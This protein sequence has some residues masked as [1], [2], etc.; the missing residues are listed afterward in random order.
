MTIT[1][2]GTSGITGDGSGLTNLTPANISAGTLP[3]LNAAALTNLTPE[4]ISAGTLPVLNAAALTNLS[5]TSLVGVLPALNAAALTN[6]TPANISAGTLPV[7]NGANLTALS[8]P[9]LVGT[10]PALNGSNLTSLNAANLTGTLPALNASNLTGL[11]VGGSVSVNLAGSSLVTVTGIAPL[12]AR[13][14]VAIHRQSFT[15]TNAGTLI[16]LGTSAGMQTTGYQSATITS[17]AIVFTKYNISS[18]FMFQSM[19]AG[20]SNSGI[21]DLVRMGAGSNQW[22]STHSIAWADGTG[23]GAGEVTLS[24]ELD[25]IMLRP[26]GSGGN[27]DAG[28]MTV[29]WSF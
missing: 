13:I 4:N 1:L 9:A 15:A 23:Q 11:P 12:A 24:G 21:W 28:R 25:R 3:I 18:G 17:L 27:H 19:A 20:E 7:L 16:Q 5:T 29:N 2:N 6:L 26:Q 10:L 14:Q 8:A 22:A